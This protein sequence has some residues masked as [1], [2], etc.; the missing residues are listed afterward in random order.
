MAKIGYSIQGLV[1]KAKDTVMANLASVQGT[2]DII[3]IPMLHALMYVR[4]M[5]AYTGEHQHLHV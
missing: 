4:L 3:I 1:A 2:P 5:H